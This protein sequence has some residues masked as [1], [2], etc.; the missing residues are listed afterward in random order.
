MDDRARG[1]AWRDAAPWELLRDL[2]PLDRLGGHAGERRGAERVAMALEEAGLDARLVPFEMRRWTRGSTTLAVEAG[3]ERSFE[4][5]ALPYS[6]AT[7]LR[8]PLRDAG[9]GTVEDCADVEGSI[10]VV[11]AAAPPGAD[12]HVHRMEKL[13]HA[14]EAGAEAF[15]LV[16]DQPGQLPPTGALRFGQP[17]RI[18]GVGVSMET[19]AWLREYAA[20]DSEP[21]STAR[22]AVDATTDPA[23]SY[24]V[25]AD[26]GP[27]TDEAVLFVAHHDAHDV[28]EGVLDNGCGVA[29]LLGAVRALA[30]AAGRDSDALGCRVAVAATG[31]EELGLLGAEAL[32]DSLDVDRLRA[33]VNVD[34]AGRFR[35]LRALVHAASPLRQAVAAAADGPDPIDVREQPHPW[36]DHWPFLRAGVPALQLHSRR[37]G[38]ED[39]ERGY[40]HTR[41]DTLDKADPRTIREHALLA[42][43]LVT[44]LT[45]TPVEPVDPDRVRERLVTAGAEPGMRAAGVWPASWDEHDS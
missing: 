4:A 24:N 12:R 5:V 43:E 21:D 28:G 31:S 29:V 1:A 9:H 14:V 32:A 27:D 42:A 3:P 38:E 33:V 30:D 35:D 2:A 23:E 6:P 41:A 34:G 19:G 7:D 45:R 39:W 37:P 8:A 13:G 20:R 36:S 22:L 25:R 16:G 10:A 11:D 18:P 17:A 44:A 15:V 40:T 26:L